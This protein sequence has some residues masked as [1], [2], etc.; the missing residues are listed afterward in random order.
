MTRYQSTF[1]KKLLDHVSLSVEKSW[2]GMKIALETE[3]YYVK[4]ECAKI[5]SQMFVKPKSLLS[6]I[7]LHGYK[8]SG[9]QR[10]TVNR[11]IISG[12][13]NI[14]LVRGKE[15]MIQKVRDDV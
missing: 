10:Q 6:R 15:I 2:G 8:D 3:K 1:L 14:K 13:F 9:L 7:C 12:P 4:G 11:N 5:N